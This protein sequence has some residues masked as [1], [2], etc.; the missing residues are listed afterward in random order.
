MKKREKELHK[1]RNQ[2]ARLEASREAAIKTLVKAEVQL[3]KL[4]S[5][6][7]RMTAKTLKRIDQEVAQLDAEHQPDLV[8]QAAPM[9][10]VNDG[11]MVAEPDIPEFLDRTKDEE[12]RA[13]IE[14]EQ[15]A[16]KKAKTERRLA[17]LKIGQEIKQAELTGQRRKMPL[18]GK[19]A[20]AAIRAGR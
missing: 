4:E 16:Q 20:L 5:K 9:G 13:E 10:M 17:K 15:A 2:I 18:T 8:K 1:L 19:E 12:A 14:A 3:P 6:L 7:R 11:E